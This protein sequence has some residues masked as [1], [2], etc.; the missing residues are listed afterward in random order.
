[1]L[2]AATVISGQY[3]S[4]FELWFS[5]AYFAIK[6]PICVICSDEL[7]YEQLSMSAH[8]S[9]RKRLHVFGPLAH[10]EFEEGTPEQAAAH[11]LLLFEILP[12]HVQTVMFFDVDTLLL[13]R[14]SDV[15]TWEQ[16]AQA[17]NF[18]ACRDRY[19]GYKE[20]LAQ[21]M[22]VLDPTFVPVFDKDGHMLYVNTG[23]F[24]ANRTHFAWRF[25]TVLREWEAFRRCA[26]RHPSILD[27]NILN[28][29]LQRDCWPVRVIS[30]RFNCLRTDSPQVH[31]GNLYDGEERVAIYHANGGEPAV[32][33]VRMRDMRRLLNR[34]IQHFQ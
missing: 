2:V 27:Q 15:S 26:G 23:F 10:L 22:S 29:V 19:V 3:L 24:V 11:K 28:Y 8:N 25:A 21:E 6:D 1:V 34:S 16:V 13:E 9:S 33:L 17:G 32:K 31:A 18:I 14:L 12:P 4:L 20:K 7:S 30:N 5:Y